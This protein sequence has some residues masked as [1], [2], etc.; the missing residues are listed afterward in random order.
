MPTE[1]AL[2]DD[3]IKQGEERIRELVE[4][5]KSKGVLQFREI[6]DALSDVPLSPQQIEEV[7]EQLAEQNIDGLEDEAEAEIE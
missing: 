6:A 5:G 1:A 4:L 7:Y 2:T 3:Q